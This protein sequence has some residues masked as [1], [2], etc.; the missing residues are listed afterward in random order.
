MKLVSVIIPVYNCEDSIGKIITGL[1]H[2]TYSELQ[3]III[4]DGSTDTTGLICKEFCDNR[5][6]YI[7]T[8]NKGPSAARNTGL[9]FATGEFIC[10]CDADDDV[11]NEYI[12][13]LVACMSEPD[14]GLATMLSSNEYQNEQQNMICNQ[15]SALWLI[16]RDDRFGGFLWNKIFIRE[17]IVENQL[18]LDEAIWMCEDLL[19]VIQ[20]I[21]VCKKILFYNKSLYKYNQENEGISA[22]KLSE[23]RVTEFYAKCSIY[24]LVF[25]KYNSKID[26]IV[27]NS[28]VSVG[29]RLYFKTIGLNNP[30][31]VQL[32]SDIKEEMD[33]QELIFLLMK[34]RPIKL[35]IFALFI[36]LFRKKY[37]FLDKEV[38]KD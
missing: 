10:F 25:R 38:S 3:I 16:L 2:Q 34:L 9:S 15:E 26:Y 19:F 32:R 8:G 14:I 22:F 17:I 4:D 18:R 6:V 28:M 7:K 31:F 36:R 21:L 27:N 5:I 20:Y 23:R 12:E 24:R 33:K 29:T 13:Q 11:D 30:T 1:L 37:K 35:R